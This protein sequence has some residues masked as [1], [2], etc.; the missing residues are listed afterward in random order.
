MDALPSQ[1]HC[2]LNTA[3]AST[4]Y[5]ASLQHNKTANHNTFAFSAKTCQPM[6]CLAVMT[7]LKPCPALLH[8]L[9]APESLVPSLKG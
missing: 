8:L 9:A 2:H 7:L 6:L 4:K 1:L 3:K 5:T